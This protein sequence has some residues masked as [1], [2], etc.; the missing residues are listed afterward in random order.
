MGN[1]QEA[2]AMLQVAAM[3]VGVPPVVA[4]EQN[5]VVFATSFLGACWQAVG[6]LQQGGDPAEVL[7]FV[8]IAGPAALAHM[9][10]FAKDPSRQ[11]IYKVMD[12]QMKKLQTTVDQIQKKFN[13]MQKQ[14]QQAKAQQ[15]PKLP[16]EVQQDLMQKDAA[17]KLKQ[18]Q[19]QEKH[20]FQMRT[21]MEK[22]ALEQDAARKRIS[23]DVARTDLT[24]AANIRATRLKA[25]SEPKKK[26]K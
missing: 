25:S 3:K 26:A 23:A 15:G 18:R 20:D 5:P 14:K 9:Q 2:E 22:T 19:S 4:P 6:S 11:G 12:A 7:Q 13:D 24:T 16:P 1:E 21:K 8:H 10:R 17:F